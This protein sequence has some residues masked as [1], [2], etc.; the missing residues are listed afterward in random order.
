MMWIDSCER[1]SSKRQGRAPK[2]PAHFGGFTQVDFDD[3][4]SQFLRMAFVRANRLS[5]VTVSGAMLNTLH[6]MCSISS[7]VTSHTF[8]RSYPSSRERSCSSRLNPAGALTG[9]PCLQ[10]SN[11]AVEV[12]GVALGVTVGFLQL[13]HSDF[14][15]REQR[16]EPFR[17]LEVGA[18]RCRC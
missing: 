7:A 9:G 17:C 6:C 13:K 5:E 3:M 10:W 1:G 12:Q 8:E 15:V 18:C 11:A 4:V 16:T 2:Q 14:T